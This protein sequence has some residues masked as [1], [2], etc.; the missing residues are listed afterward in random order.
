[1]GLVA[2]FPG[3]ASGLLTGDGSVGVWH[4]GFVVPSWS[5]L[6]RAVR[7]RPVTEAL[8]GLERLDTEASIRRL[9]DLQ[10]LYPSVGLV[11]ACTP[12][13][14]ARALFEVGRACG[15]L[16]VL[17][18]GVDDSPRRV[19][20]ALNQASPRRTATRVLTALRG[21]I[22]EEET[23]VVHSVLEW[24]HR[25][26]PARRMAGAFGY[27]RPF[28]SE[29]LKARGLPSIG[30]LQL[31]ARLFHAATWLSDPGRSA[32]SVAVQLEYADGAGFRRA[33]RKCTGCTPTEIVETGG[34]GRVLE[35]F[36]LECETLR[37]SPGQ[38]GRVA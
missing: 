26:W 3:S 18:R 19:M 20:A 32:E 21:R 1:M 11:L 22:P 5:A 16:P 7:D 13:V 10:R 35:A 37:S 29:R 27:S 9:R 14:D 6:E 28:L 31:W 17:I 33:L 38:R 4:D 23:E 36:F 15:R 24:S 25:C 12:P 2:S 30:R 34:L 8:I